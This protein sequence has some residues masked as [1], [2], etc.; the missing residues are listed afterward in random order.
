MRLFLSWLF[1]P[2]VFASLGG[3]AVTGWGLLKFGSLG[4]TLAFFHGHVLYAGLGSKNLGKIPVNKPVSVSFQVKNLTSQTVKV[5]GAET[6]CGC[7]TVSDLPVK[8]GAGA[9][10]ELTFLLVPPE[11]AVGMPFYQAVR[12]FLDVPG[13][14]VILQME[15]EVVSK[16]EEVGE[17]IRHPQR[18]T[19]ALATVAKRVISGKTSPWL[20]RGF[21]PLLK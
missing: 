19:V 20:I 4:A 21:Y 2:L 7:I 6:S 5:L 10:C 8:I 13:P 3:V 18:S 16:E 14:T 9:E 17:Y 1:W 12:L 15:A 11:Q